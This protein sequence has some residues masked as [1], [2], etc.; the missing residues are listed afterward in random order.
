[1][2]GIIGEITTYAL[3]RDIYKYDFIV[4]MATFDFLENF[5]FISLAITFGLILMLVYHFKS[6]IVAVEKQ[7]DLMNEALT[8]VLKTCRSLMEQ[9]VGIQ[10]LAKPVYSPQMPKEVI[11]L[12]SPVV[13]PQPV[14]V[15]KREDHIMYQLREVDNED[16]QSEYSSDADEEEDNYND[17]DD[18]GEST[19]SD[20]AVTVDENQLDSVSEAD[21]DDDVMDEVEVF[22]VVSEPSS[23]NV[24]E[25][26]V[27]VVD[28]EGENITSVDE[29]PV[30]QTDE[31]PIEVVEQ[32]V[33]SMDDIDLGKVENDDVSAKVEEV[34]V[35]ETTELHP[36]TNVATSNDETMSEVSIFDKNAKEVYRK[37]SI[38]QLRTIAVSSG[39]TV[40]TTKMK[41]NDLIK[42]LLQSL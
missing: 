39:I 42:L 37:M 33:V 7:M 21:T 4:K 26:M 3:L 29:M 10:H 5:F 35:T 15:P 41:K 14:I 8:G 25:E 24:M 13:P 18:I 6:R 36:P 9:N 34:V 17:A 38:G 20:D 22:H 30:I 31:A 27:E 40:D 32:P 16:D 23:H 28:M 11:D 1:L 2:Y 12:S 19:F